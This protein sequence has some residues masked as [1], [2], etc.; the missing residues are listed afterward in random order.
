LHE[1]GAESARQKADTLKREAEK[2]EEELIEER[3]RSTEQSKTIEVLESERRK[4][5]DVLN[6]SK[7]ALSAVV[8]DMADVLTQ[9][10]NTVL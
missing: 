1:T 8:N 6:R 5:R 9:A 4:C 2:N 10:N 7:A 3:M